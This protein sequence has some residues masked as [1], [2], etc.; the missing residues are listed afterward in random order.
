M[1]NIEKAIKTLLD[2]KPFYAYFFLDSRISYDTLGV[3]TAGVRAIPTGV[4]FIFNTEWVNQHKPEQIAAIIEHEVLHVLFE[5]VLLYKDPNI[6]KHIANIAQ[7]AS[8][9]QFI[10]SLPE[11][12]VTIE[13]LEKE[14]NIKLQRE[15][16]WEYYYSKLIK[17]KDKLQNTTTLDMHDL[18][19]ELVGEGKPFQ[20]KAAL[21]AAVD[22]AMKCS[23]GNVPQAV[24]KAY[25]ALSAEQKVPWQQVLS[26]FVARASSSISRSTRKKT[27]RRFGMEQP[28]K[29]KK[30][31]LVLGV[32]ADSSGSISEESFQQFLAEIVRI[33]KHCQKVIYVDAD[34]EVQK[35]EVLKKNKPPKLER[36]G[37]G[38]TAY[39][40]AI[41][42]CMEHKV[43]AIIYFGDFDSSDTPTNPGVPFLWVGV[44][45]QNPPGNFGSVIRI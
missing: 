23:K 31:E 15:Q 19:S 45:E 36:H 14:L 10:E 35:V 4:E 13:A 33:S 20:S 12:C 40:P 25:D 44:G 3:P 16:T 42:K 28:G 32:C 11:N 30:R 29:I 34:C 9:N 43:D 21:K 2:D 6:E 5:H 27:N 38:G 37:F 24:L 39:Q 17:H 18:E 22:R 1:N 41:N 26:N 7:D 8:I